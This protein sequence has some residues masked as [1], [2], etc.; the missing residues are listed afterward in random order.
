MTIPYWMRNAGSSN[1]C[2]RDYTEALGRAIFNPRSGIEKSS[3]HEAR[4]S[5]RIYYIYYPDRP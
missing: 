2:A 5:V 4:S 1:L 3:R